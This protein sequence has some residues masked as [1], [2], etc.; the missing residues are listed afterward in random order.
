MDYSI[1]IC[2][3]FFFL[4]HPPNPAWPSPPST[5]FF[6]A[7]PTMLRL[8][9]KKAYRSFSGKGGRFRNWRRLLKRDEHAQR[10]SVFPVGG[11]SRLSLDRY[12]VFL[13]LCEH[14]HCIRS[15][16]HCFCLCSMH[17]GVEN[18]LDGLTSMPR[19]RQSYVSVK[20]TSGVI[21][22]VSYFGA[23]ANLVGHLYHRNSPHDV[24]RIKLAG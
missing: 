10:R 17:P 18:K 9:S 21:S 13:F 15:S 19:K 12:G 23:R 3:K 2:V 5:D 24:E 8:T 16:V 11:T 4:D 1:S 6:P 22:D 14:W 7:T 20:S